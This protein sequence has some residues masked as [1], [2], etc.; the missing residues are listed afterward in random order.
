MASTPN[1]ARKCVGCKPHEFQDQ[2]Y[3]PGMR[4]FTIGKN[5]RTCSVCG[6]VEQVQDVEKAKK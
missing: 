1:K 3:G 2:R 4:M 6:K 5:K